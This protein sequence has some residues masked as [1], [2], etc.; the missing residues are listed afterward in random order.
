MFKKI[1]LW[2]LYLVL[3]LGLPFIIGFGFLVRQELVGSQKF[4]KVSKT[5]LFLSEIPANLKWLYLQKRG[6]QKLE[7]RFPN[8]IGFYGKPNYKESYILLT[9]YNG[10]LKQ[11]VVELVDLRDFQVFGDKRPHI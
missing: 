7:D 5:A 11:G 1:E 8:K 2:I 6:L 4:G 3:L 10:D 9:K